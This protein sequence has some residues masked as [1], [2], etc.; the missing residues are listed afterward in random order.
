MALTES[1]AEFLASNRSA[2]MITVGADGT[3]KAVRVGVTV[4]DGE[5]WSSGTHDRVR[6]RRL[7]GDPRCTLFVYEFG[8]RAL[9][10]ETTVEILEG[11]QVADQSVR[12]FRAMQ[13]RPDGPLSLYGE[14]LDE[15]KFRRAMIDQG[16][17]IYEFEV[18]KA[19]G[20]D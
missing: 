16:R 9:T 14:E 1:Q 15:E 10:L 13:N 18:H 8:F 2:A 11:P 5:I 20:L 19:Y 17:I 7:R 12:L 3:P 6:T 4:V